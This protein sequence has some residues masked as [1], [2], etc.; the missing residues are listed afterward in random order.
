MGRLVLI[1]FDV[2]VQQIFERSFSPEM[3]NHIFI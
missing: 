2:T 1:D 3:E